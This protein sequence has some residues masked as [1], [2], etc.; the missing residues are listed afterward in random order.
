MHITI[1]VDLTLK[2]EKSLSKRELNENLIREDRHW[3]YNYM[4]IFNKFFKRKQ[5]FLFL[6][7]AVYEQRLTRLVLRVQYNKILHSEFK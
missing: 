1:A 6:V 4:S 5:I 3:S 7:P 2:I